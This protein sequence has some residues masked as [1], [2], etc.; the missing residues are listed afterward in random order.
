M[1]QFKDFEPGP[2]TEGWSLTNTFISLNCQ[3]ICF[4]LGK[5]NQDQFF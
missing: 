5:K 1:C 4:A 3:T 2:E